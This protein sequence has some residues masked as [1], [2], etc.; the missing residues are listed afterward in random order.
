MFKH[1]DS[2]IHSKYNAK[3]FIQPSLKNINIIASKITRVKLHV[4]QSKRV[5]WEMLNYITRY[6]VR[7]CYIHLLLNKRIETIV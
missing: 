6:D 5:T 2:K 1:K 3:R 4:T 7:Y